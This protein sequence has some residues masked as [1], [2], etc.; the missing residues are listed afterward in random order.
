MIKNAAQMQREE[1]MMAETEKRETA[2]YSCNTM[3]EVAVTQDTILELS[4]NLDDMTAEEIGFAMDRLYEAGAA[5]VFTIAAGTK[6][7]RPSVLLTVLCAEERKEEIVRTIFV[8]TTT[9]GIREQ[10]RNRYVL[11]RT[12]AEVDTPFGTVHRK[13]CSGYG[14]RKSKF[15][16]EDLA[17]LAKEKGKSIRE[18]RE[19][20]L[21]SERD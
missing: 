12:V 10:L 6:K 2:G 8:H 21:Q 19:Q 4:C 7:N 3:N 15:E 16:F 11:K 14:V 1:S 17:R 5:E 9:I 20:L 13:D 18:I